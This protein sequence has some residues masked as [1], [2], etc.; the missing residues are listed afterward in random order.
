MLGQ[1]HHDR[2]VLHC[3]RSVARG[4]HL[5]E[6][7]ALGSAADVPC[8]LVSAGQTI[9]LDG[10]NFGNAADTF[11]VRVGTSDC[12]NPILLSGTRLTCVLGT[13]S[14]LSL[15]VTLYRNQ[16]FSP[17]VNSL[18]YATAT[19]LSV[20]GCTDV[21]S[22]T[23]FC[24][25][26]G[27]NVVYLI[28]ANFGPNPTVLVGGTLC[29]NLVADAT[30]PNSLLHCTLA[31][32]SQTGVTVSVIQS[33]GS[34]SSNAS[35]TV[36][37]T[38]CPAGTISTGTISCTVCLVGTYQGLAGQSQCLPCPDG[39]YAPATAAVR[40]TADTEDGEQATTHG[41]GWTGPPCE[42]TVLLCCVL[43]H[44]F[45]LVSTVPDGLFDLFL[46][47]LLSECGHGREFVPVLRRR[48]V[49][50]DGRPGWVPR[51]PARHLRQSHRPRSVRLVPRRFVRRLA[52][53]DD[54]HVLL[55]RHLRVGHRLLLLQPVRHR[56]QVDT[57]RRVELV[58]IVHA[59][60]VSGYVAAGECAAKLGGRP[61]H[62][63]LF[64]DCDSICNVY[65]RSDHLLVVPGRNL[66]AERRPRS[67]ERAGMAALGVAL[68]GGRH[69]SSSSSGCCFLVQALAWS[70]LLALPRPPRLPRRVPSAVPAL[71]LSRSAVWALRRAR[72]VPLARTIRWWDKAPACRAR[73]VA[74]AR[75][76]ASAAAR[77][78]RSPTTPV[79]LARPRATRV[80]LVPRVPSMAQRSP[81]LRAASVSTIHR[82]ANRLVSRVDRA[83]PS[84][85]RARPHVWRACRAKI[86]R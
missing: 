45:V 4:S 74:L 66:S 79:R 59:R 2:V 67:V 6:R 62:E 25:R 1:W 31:A 23:T 71:T 14:G 5:A 30:S 10:S 11:A 16:L 9:T 38:P 7:A 36:S 15:P 35:A 82:P 44:A 8:C 53:V 26:T 81:A 80:R 51:V 76:P 86:S 61:L 73:P 29:S 32:G 20:A 22:S 43:T 37:F 63:V 64:A 49:Q 54:V 60:N 41:R 57:H 65:A 50:P 56:L 42:M 68:A 84:R 19:I 69:S 39:Q 40:P 33:G 28:G 85:R 52:V 46:R 70:A 34:L 12:L 21:A 48:H 78:A 58:Y 3:G 18:S 72:R 24:N 13:G 47:H 55:R 27:G 83:P 75:P 77:S 17:P